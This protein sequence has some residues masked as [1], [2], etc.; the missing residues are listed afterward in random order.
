VN[1][2]KIEAFWEA[3]RL[4]WSHETHVTTFLSVNDGLIDRV[5]T[6]RNFETLGGTL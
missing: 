2:N 1:C 5:P 6:L 3:R 4:Q